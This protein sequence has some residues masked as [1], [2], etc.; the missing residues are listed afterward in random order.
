MAAVLRTAFCAGVCL[1]LYLDVEKMVGPARK[2]GKQTLDPFGE[3]QVRRRHLREGYAQPRTDDAER[4]WSGELENVSQ[5]L[6]Q[7]APYILAVLLAARKSCL[8]SRR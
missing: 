3:R 8:R 7:P 1:G 5:V 6:A 2:V 4:R